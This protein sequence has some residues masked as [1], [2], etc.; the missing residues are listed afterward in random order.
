MGIK[1]FSLSGQ[2]FIN[3]LSQMLFDKNRL[4]CCYIS[5]L[6]FLLPHLSASD[7]S[8]EKSEKY[9]IYEISCRKNILTNCSIGEDLI[10]SLTLIPIHICNWK[11]KVSLVK[12]SLKPPQSYQDVLRVETVSTVERIQVSQ[13]RPMFRGNPTE[14][15]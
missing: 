14:R 5:S 15:Q 9:K 1:T 3:R 11:L 10:F 8:M 6:C 12:N 13:P 7:S 2:V 4:Y